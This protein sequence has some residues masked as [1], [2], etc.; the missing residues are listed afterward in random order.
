MENQNLQEPQ[1][2]IPNPDLQQPRNS[3]GNNWKRLIPLYIIVGLILYAGIY[4]ALSK[5]KSKSY[6]P[7]VV[8]PSA[9]QV[10]SSPTTVMQKEGSANV[11]ADQENAKKQAQAFY[12]EWLT[13]IAPGRGVT[14][15]AAYLE[16]LEKK[17]YITK[18]AVTQI[19]TP[20]AFDLITCSQN[21]LA[22]EFYK[23]STPVVTG[24]NATMTVTG[25]YNG[26]GTPIDH[27]IT[28]NLIKSNTQWSINSFT[29]PP[30][31]TVAQ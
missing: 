5:E 16:G 25:S 12:N 21:P 30:E 20:K 17:G 9:Q 13:T 4:Y 11:A 24:S 19:K 14:D 28:L 31:P 7:S 26:T 15:I 10:P 8:K 23:F 22:F 3:Y 27:V 6:V 1:S 2:S 29:C 18:N